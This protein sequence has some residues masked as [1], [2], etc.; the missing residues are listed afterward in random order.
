MRTR[1]SALAITCLSTLIAMMLYHKWKAYR[2]LKK[3]KRM[4][5]FSKYPVAGKTKT[6]LISTLGSSGAATLQL[7][8]VSA[9]RVFVSVLSVQCVRSC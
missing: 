9:R 8:M 1:N 4:L 7:L 6:R 3:K 2:A 5:V